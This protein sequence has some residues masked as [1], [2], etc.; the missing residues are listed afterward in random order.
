MQVEF[1][2][3]ICMPVYNNIAT[4]SDSLK[5]M[6]TGKIATDLYNVNVYVNEFLRLYNILTIL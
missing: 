5:P 6:L 3:Q 2:D 1:I 4:L